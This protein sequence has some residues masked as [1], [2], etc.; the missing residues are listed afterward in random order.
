MGGPQ[1]VVESISSKNVGMSL[2]KYEY[3]EAMYWYSLLRIWER[4]LGAMV[5]SLFPY[6]C[7]WTYSENPMLSLLCRMSHRIIIIGSPGGY[8]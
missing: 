6:P 4:S 1:K 7:Q 2:K 8:G 5:S 3:L